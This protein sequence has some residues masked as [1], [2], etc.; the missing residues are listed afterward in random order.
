MVL[1]S[2]S[3]IG[4]NNV[5][6]FETNGK[7]SEEVKTFFKLYINY[8]SISFKIHDNPFS[9]SSCSLTALTNSY[10]LVI[11]FVYSCLLFSILLLFYWQ[12]QLFTGFLQGDLQNSQE[13]TRNR[14]FFEYSFSRVQYFKSADFS[15]QLR[16]T[17][18]F[19][20]IMVLA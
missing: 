16:G 12:K 19:K 2:Y 8:P 1:T 10:S 20:N 18:L 15:E 4:Q 7:L 3:C 9:L 5:V 6:Y 17:V 14:A 11:I 13:E